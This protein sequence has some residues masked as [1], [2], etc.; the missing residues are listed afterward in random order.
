[1][2]LDEIEESSN[3][4]DRRGA[5]P[6][7]RLAVGGGIGTIV[8]AL[9][10]ML[11]GGDPQ[12]VMDMASQMQTPSSQTQS[13]D[14]GKPVPDDENSIL[15]KKV[16]KDTEDV[17]ERIFQDQLGKQY[18]KPVLVFFTDQV[19]SACG[20][21]SS[22]MGPFYCPGDDQVYIDTSFFR[23][24]REQLG[25]AGDFAQA[26]VVAHEVGHHVQNLLGTNSMVN[27][28]RRQSSQREGNQLSV[29]MELQADFYAGVWA[30]HAQD[31]L[32]LD[33]QDIEE[34]LNAANQIGD[35]TLQRKSQGTVV[36][37]AFTHGTSE[38]RMRWFMKGFKSG[39][40]EDGDTFKT[41]NL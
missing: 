35:D 3:I 18:K 39:R 14:P 22:A 30:Y 37:D 38:Q 9:V 8:I 28:L 15:V 4:D 32:Q 2:R 34:A 41:R 17:W 31:R 21:A 7:G 11:L 33:Q 5:S 29:R 25:A 10:V 23:T 13:L 40:L 24:M 6:N 16:L 26:Y 1:M 36:P 12:Q 19:S 27:K 20:S